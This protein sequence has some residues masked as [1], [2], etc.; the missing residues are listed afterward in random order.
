MEL[1]N[2]VRNQRLEHANQRK[3]GKKSCMTPERY[4][5]LDDVGFKWSIPTPARGN[6]KSVVESW[7]HAQQTAAAL[8]EEDVARAAPDTPTLPVATTDAELPAIT[9]PDIGGETL[10]QNPCIADV[11]LGEEHVAV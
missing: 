5:L 6:R 7:R 4:K 11:I 3:I 9:A 2:W 8:S 10:A 1:A